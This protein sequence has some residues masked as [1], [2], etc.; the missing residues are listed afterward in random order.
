M[1]D[2]PLTHVFVRFSTVQGRGVD[3]ISV[4][5][6]LSLSVDAIRRVRHRGRTVFPQVRPTFYNCCPTP[7]GEPK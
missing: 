2:K 7:Q 3:G 1:T 6:R 5:S 4:H